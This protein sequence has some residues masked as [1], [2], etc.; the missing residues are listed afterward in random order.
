MRISR[1]MRHLLLPFAVLLAAAP[2]A[3]PAAPAGKLLSYR[4]ASG[5]TAVYNCKVSSRAEGKSDAGNKV[6][7]EASVQMRCTTE[8]LGDTASGDYGVR[9]AIESGTLNVKVDGTQDEAELP[10]YVERFIVSTRGEIK[11]QSVLSGDP[12]V[13][14]YGGLVLVLGPD[15]PLL[16]GGTAIFPDKPIRKGDK[17]KGTAHVPLPQEGEYNDWKY[18]ST[19]LG[20]EA[21]QGRNCHKIKTTSSGAISEAIEAPDGSGTLKV[22]AKIANV[23]TWLFDSER[24]LIVYSERSA[25]LSATVKAIVD[26]EAVAS[27][28]TSGVIN[29]KNV[30]TEYNGIAIGQK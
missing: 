11:Q 7:A 3:F 9:G 29:E 17:W 19:L 25:R 28:T 23:D 21:W 16:L 30:L 5:D 4:Y 22:S 12:P 8:F 24:G 14:M 20:E 10:E 13:L 27:I 26:G 6:R 18:E 2:A 1:V 15:E